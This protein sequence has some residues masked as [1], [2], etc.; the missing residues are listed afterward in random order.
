MHMYGLKY[1]KIYTWY[2]LGV[3]DRFSTIRTQAYIQTANTETNTTY[4]NYC[5]TRLPCFKIWASLVT[6]V[7]HEITEI[8]NYRYI[9]VVPLHNRLPR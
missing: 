4:D 7:P 3:I 8:S 6:R 5:F 1:I 9:A 2:L